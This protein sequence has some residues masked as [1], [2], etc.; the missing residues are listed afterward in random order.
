MGDWVQQRI[1]ERGLTDEDAQQFS[2]YFC[3][4]EKN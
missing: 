1:K 2:F 4:A 3:M